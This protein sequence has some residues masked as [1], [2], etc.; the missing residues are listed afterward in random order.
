MAEHRV[1]YSRNAKGEW[2]AA[3]RGLRRARGRG[4]TLRQAR[5]GLRSALARLVEE[6]YSIDFLEDV[7]LPP[8]VRRLIVRHWAARRRLEQAARAADVAA[9]AALDAVLDQR[10]GPRDAADLLGLPPLK[11]QKLR[12]QAG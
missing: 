5:Q 9:R 10:I 8:P 4:R 7:R 12:H 11:L 3:V 2:V 1:V 6:P